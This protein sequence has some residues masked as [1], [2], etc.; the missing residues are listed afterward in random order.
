MKPGKKYILGFSQNVITRM[1][2]WGRRIVDIF[3]ILYLKA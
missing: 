2:F 3:A 1:A